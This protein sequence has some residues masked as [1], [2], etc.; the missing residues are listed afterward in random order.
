MLFFDL[1]RVKRHAGAY[2]RG[3]RCGAEG[4][5]TWSG[6]F[7]HNRPLPMPADRAAD[8]HKRCVTPIFIVLIELWISKVW[9]DPFFDTK[10]FELPFQP[11]WRDFLHIYDV[12]NSPNLHLMVLNARK[13]KKELQCCRFWNGYSSECGS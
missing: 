6:G 13:V 3:V 4:D 10:E 2:D 7:C 11:F 12:I 5:A 1:V 8:R 9:K